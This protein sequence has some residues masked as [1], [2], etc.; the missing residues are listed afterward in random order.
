VLLL[1][2]DYRGF[3]VRVSGSGKPSLGDVVRYVPSIFLGFLILG[4]TLSIGWYSWQNKFIRLKRESDQIAGLTTVQRRLSD[5]FP[6]IV[7]DLLLLVSEPRLQALLEHN[8]ETHRQS[9]G[10]E[11]R[12]WCKTKKEYYEIRLIDAEGKEWIRV[13]SHNGSPYIVA[14]EE[15]Q[16]RSAR[17]FFQDSFKLGRGEV[18]VSPLDLNVEHDKIE[19]PQHPTIRF[20]IPVFDKRDR[21]RG[22]I[23]IN[24]EGQLLLDEVNSGLY[25]SKSRIQL[26]NSDGYWLKGIQPEDDWGFMTDGGTHRTF[27]NSFPSAWGLIAND[28]SGAFYTQEGFFAFRTLRPLS[29]ISQ[30]QAT[31]DFQANARRSAYAWKV[32]SHTSHSEIATESRQLFL[33][34][35]IADAVSLCLLMGGLWWYTRTRMESDRCDLEI[36]RLGS[37]L[38]L[39]QDAI[40]VVNTDHRVTFWNQGAENQYGWTKKDAI[41]QNAITLLH[42]RFPK[43]FQEIEA[44]LFATGT[45]EGETS[46]ASRTGDESVS[47]SRCSI[48]LNDDGKPVAVLVINHDITKRKQV[49]DELRAAH[50]EIQV[51]FNA[52]PSILIGLD[53]RGQI[54]RWNAAAETLFGLRLTDVCGKTLGKCGIHWLRETLEAEI[55]EQLRMHDSRHVENV[56]FVSD[57]KTQFLGI[58][59]LSITDGGTA[60]GIL[61][62]GADVT[63]RIVLEA[64]LRQAQ[65]LEAIGQLAAGVAHEINT[66][67]QFIGDNTRF[68]RETWGGVGNVLRA[69]REMRRGFETGT[70]TPEELAAFDQASEDADLDYALDEVPKAIDQT[71]EGVQRVAKI[72]QSMKEFSHPG[73]EDKLP[74]NINRAIETTVAVARNEWKYVADVQTTLDKELPLVPCFAAEFNQVIL[75]LLVNASHAIADVVKKDGGVGVIRI[76]T[77]R[78]GDWA[79]VRIQDSGGGIPERIHTRIFEP[80]FTTKEV[81]KGTG[82][83]LALV[84]SVIVKK[85]GGKIW[86]ECKK[87]GGTTFIIRLPLNSTQ[88]TP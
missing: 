16:D 64:Q 71:L 20:C 21:K 85:H 39:A 66:P 79:E 26:V 30:P 50:K 9:L 31:P 60:A 25:P 74:V 14:T 42:T 34:V 15:L 48:E 8:D 61:I 19:Q 22:V 76:T 58:T 65:K 49:E 72:V 44:E 12:R 4:I 3:V 32:V 23:V 51:L 46:R 53:N 10:E 6:P 37:L 68:L 80:F 17:Y 78:D 57:G 24:Y 63:E 55:S 35:A 40:Y 29:N 11:L 82:Q 1:F 13:N 77:Q 52:I 84:H 38:D 67:T 36:Q 47:I 81:G 73:S 18:Y 2:K 87:G 7:V 5:A 41:G 62:V 69:A 43:P 27:V 70:T 33:Q 59:L 56:P 54:I 83:G 45:W 88:E 28:E 86:F 75:N